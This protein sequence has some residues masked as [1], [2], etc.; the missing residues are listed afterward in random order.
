MTAL[1]SQNHFKK[2]D[3]GTQTLRCHFQHLQPKQVFLIRIRIIYSDVDPAN[4]SVPYKSGS[5]S[6]TLV[7]T[8]SCTV[9]SVNSTVQ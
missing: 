7:L 6:A 4:E 1:T 9:Y 5:E 8:D 2:S 3:S